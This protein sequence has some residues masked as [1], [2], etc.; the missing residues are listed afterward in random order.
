VKSLPVADWLGAELSETGTTGRRAPRYRLVY[1]GLRRAILERRLAAG[2]RLPSTRELASELGLS[3]NTIVT[4]F[5]QLTAEGYISTLTGSGTFVTDVG[6][7]NSARPQKSALAARRP[8]I[9]RRGRRLI[10]EDPGAAQ[11]IQPFVPGID[12]FSSFPIKI[13]QRLQNKYW[14]EGRSAL[15]DNGP[16]GGYLPLREAIARHVS[17]A[18]SVRVDAEQILITSGTQHSLMLCA[19]IL[20]NAGDLAWVEDPGYWGARK[21]MSAADLVL[22]PIRVD[23][24]GINPSAADLQTEPRLIYVTPSHHYPTSAVMSLARR[25]ALLEFAG[26]RGSWVLEDDYDSEFRYTGRPLS[27]LQGLDNDDCVIYMVT[28]SKS[29]YPGIKLA[30]LAVP[31]AVGEDFKS[32]LYDLQRPGQLMMQAALADFIDQGHFATHMRKVRGIYGARR[33]LLVKTLR[34]IIGKLGTV[35]REASGLHLLIELPDTTNDVALAALVAT[36]GLV[37]RPLSSYYLGETVRRG[38]LVGYAYVPTHA[39]ARHARRLGELIK[40]GLRSDG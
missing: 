33:E 7:A 14:R 5:D 13:W 9:A 35:S 20:A 22:R 26:G 4:A 32:A 40:R 10:Q 38:L 19:Q 2:A 29:L 17:L 28:F 39:I 36:E 8:V 30:Y 18:R 24:E 12:D 23:G 34:P 1:E 21:A 25:R 31:A 16:A 3:R 11:E 27:S 15:L 6:A 37:V